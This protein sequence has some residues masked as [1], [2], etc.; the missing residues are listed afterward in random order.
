MT[1]ASPKLPLLIPLVFLALACWL[2]VHLAHRQGWAVQDGLLS[3][4]VLIVILRALWGSLRGGRR[5]RERRRLGGRTLA[6]ID[7]MSGM[8]FERWL[9]LLLQTGGF[10]IQ[11]T[12]LTGD[13]GIDLILAIDGVRLGI[14]AKRRGPKIS[15]EIVRSAQAGAQHHRCSGLAIVT[16]SSFS[17]HAARQ[18]A[19]SPIPIGLFGRQD[20]MALPARLR[21]LARRC[22]ACDD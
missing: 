12:P 17:P 3:V 19:T 6:E 18:A 7:R 20:L 2:G 4:L 8:Q 15:N 5:A 1:L 11:T 16:Q 22:Q 10:E 14:E 9:Q 13:F 21:E